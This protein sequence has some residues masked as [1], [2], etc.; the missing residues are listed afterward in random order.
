MI[1][2]S[3]L[4]I[5]LG[6]ALIVFGCLQGGWFL[7]VVW[8]GLDFFILGIAHARGAQ[9]VFGK[10]PNGTLPWWSWSLFFP[11]LVYT[12]MVWHCIRLFSREPAWAVVNEQLVIGRRVLGAE[13]EQLEGEFE[14]FVDL[15]AEFPEPAAVRSAP[16]YRNFPILDRSAPDAEALREAVAGV[17][18]GRIFIH[19]AQ[20]HGRSAL[21]ALALLLESGKARTVDDGL[22]ILSA[23]RPGICLSTEQQRCIRAYAR[24]LSREKGNKPGVG[25]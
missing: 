7:I 12:G 17:R 11:L 13:L 22:R 5:F 8:L 16:C 1:R 10:K 21:F 25:S 9:R 19:C 4:L 6:A 2:Y 24:S 3:H 20:G 18:T 14:H 23:A 15:T